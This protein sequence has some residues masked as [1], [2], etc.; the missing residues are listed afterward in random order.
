MVFAW[1][2]PMM[3]MSY[4]VCLF[5]LGLTLLVITPLI[6]IRQKGWNGDVNVSPG[7]RR[8]CQKL[9]IGIRLRSFIWLRQEWQEPLLYSALSGYTT[10]WTSKV[11]RC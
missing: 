8:L 4:S 2:C 7:S 9:T 3:F 10:L 5:L 11:M 1:Q 6:Q